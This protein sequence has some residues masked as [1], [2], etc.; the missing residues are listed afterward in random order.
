MAKRRNTNFFVVGLPRSRTAF[1]ANFLTYDGHYCYHEAINGCN[2]MDEY[3]EKLGN[4]IGDSS[5]AL[6]IMDIEKHYPDAPIIKIVGN[7]DQSIKSSKKIYEEVDEEWIEFLDYQLKQ[8]TSGNCLNI[9]ID[10]LDACLPHIWKYL[11]GYEVDQERLD[12]LLNMRVE[13]LDL[14]AFDEEALENFFNPDKNKF[15]V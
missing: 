9:H 3:K 14:K 13:M 11:F 7:L 6:M 15:V 4:F 5:T 12:M 1:M 2:T 8:M 10:E